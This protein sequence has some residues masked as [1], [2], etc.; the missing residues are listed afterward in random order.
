[1]ERKGGLVD[2]IA[3]FFIKDTHSSNLDWR[4]PIIPSKYCIRSDSLCEHPFSEKSFYV[5]TDNVLVIFRRET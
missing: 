1:M 3:V 5:T 2:A 4:L